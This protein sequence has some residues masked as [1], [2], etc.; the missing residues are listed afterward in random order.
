MTTSH[1]QVGIIGAGF[2]GLCTAIRLKQS[3]SDDFVLF[4]RD[5]GI[6]GTW[7][8]NTYPGA[9]CDIPSALYSFSFAPNPDWT[10]LYPLQAEI[11]GYLQDC[12]RRF[13]VE[14]HIRFNDDVTDAQW[15]DDAQLWRITTASGHRCTVSTLVAATGPF[16]QPSVPVID[17]MADF[18]GPVLH[19]AKW[20]HSVDLTG[21]RVAVIGTGASAVQII[22]QLQPAVEQLVVFQRTATWIMPHPDRPVSPRTRRTFRRLPVLQR[23]LR[24][25]VNLVQEA[26]VP[27]LIYQP[28]LLK[29]AEAIG[30]WHLRRQIADPD[31]RAKL[32]PHYTFGCKR[33]TFSNKYFPAMAAANTVVETAPVERITPTGIQA[34]DGQHYEL[35]AIIL[36]TGFDITG[37]DGF[38]RI[39]GR[40]GRTL[41]QTWADD[42]MSTHLG[43]TIAGFPNLYMI[44]GPNSAIYTSQVVTIEA[45]VD[46]IMSALDLMRRRGLRSLEVRPEVQREFVAKTDRVLA[47]SAWNSGGCSS[48]YLGAGGR[49]VTFWPGFARSFQNRMRRLRAGDFVARVAGRSA[50]VVPAP[51]PAEA[52][53]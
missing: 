28:A 42:A 11:K 3:G 17:G 26:M 48:Y 32:T 40:H 9:Q 24:E 27:G 46:Y 5:S 47:G 31:L 38:N 50:D 16:S 18:D 20:D 43:T 53:R 33:P 41:A 30:R 51:V 15:S 39:R 34:R 19:S 6:G 2:G 21:K 10:R 37:N 22:P 25:S 1:H 13:D 12:A 29:S 23:A 4:E 49:N 14:R 52:V 35:D 7:H 44:L 45:Q 8:A 36:A